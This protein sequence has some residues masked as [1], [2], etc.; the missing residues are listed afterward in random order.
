VAKAVA[1]RPLH[2]TLLGSSSSTPG[3]Q[4]QQQPDAGASSHGGLLQQQ[5]HANGSSSGAGTGSSSGDSSSGD[6]SH[7]FSL[8]ASWLRTT[9]PAAQLTVRSGAVAGARSEFLAACLQQ[10]VEPHTDLV[11]LEVG[12]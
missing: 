5:Q 11:F 6:S 1:G 2:I 7:W 10:H 12:V 9:F 8:F 3:V 4:Q